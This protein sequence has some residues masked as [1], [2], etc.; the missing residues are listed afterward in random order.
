MSA[1]FF[2]GPPAWAL[3][4]LALLI[5]FVVPQRVQRAAA[6]RVEPDEGVTTVSDQLGGMSAETSS[7]GTDC[8]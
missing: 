1:G 4:A 5:Q 8:C 7:S 3:W 6:S 2:D